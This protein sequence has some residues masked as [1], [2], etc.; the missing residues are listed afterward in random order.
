MPNIIKQPDLVWGVD[1]VP[2]D[3]FYQLSQTLQFEEDVGSEQLYALWLWMET[4]WDL[5]FERTQDGG[6]RQ[7]GTI[8]TLGA[9]A[10]D[11]FMTI[12]SLE[13][14]IMVYA[15][16]MSLQ[17]TE[18]LASESNNCTTIYQEFSLSED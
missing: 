18:L 3:E 13:F 6:D 9:T 12:M 4:T 7:I 16:Q 11:Q 2:S 15:E 5:S 14:P 10:F 1:I 17:F 8:G